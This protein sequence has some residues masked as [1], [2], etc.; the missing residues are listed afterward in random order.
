M[1]SA[2]LAVVHR[3]S[4][5]LRPLLQDPAEVEKLGP[6]VADKGDEH[7]AHEVDV[8]AEAI[9]FETLDE[10]GYR[11]TVY[12]EER[13]LVVLGDEERLLVCDPYCNTTLTFRGFRESA[14]AAY[15]HAADGTFVA[16]AIADLQVRRI[17]HAEAGGKTQTL[18]PPAP[19]AQRAAGVSDVQEVKDA[20]IVVSLLKAKRRASSPPRLLADAGMVTTIDGAITAARL[21]FGEIDGFVDDVVGQPF[22]EALAYQMVEQAGGT[23][24]DGRG[25]PVDF[26][27][28]A[29]SLARGVVRRQSV[30]AASTAALH[31]EIMTRLDRPTA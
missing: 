5:K 14:V 17:L 13:G 2:A 16:G 10:I 11:G 8:S 25:E 12:S 20:F 28:I 9:L 31:R 6:V 29:R 3:I 24:T 19:D 1:Q 21:G 7:T 15:E 30:V 26:P 27:G 23:V 22:Y 18:W 4:E